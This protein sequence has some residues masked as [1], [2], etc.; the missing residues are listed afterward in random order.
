MDTSHAYFPP[1]I[2]HGPPISQIAAR[3]HWYWAYMG[4]DTTQV[5]DS[6]IATSI[7]PTLVLLGLYGYVPRV[8]SA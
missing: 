5:C 3:G 8:L 2:D 7:R 6:R 4:I 1:D